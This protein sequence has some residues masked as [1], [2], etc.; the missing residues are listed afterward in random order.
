MAKVPASI[1]ERGAALLGGELVESR[2]IA[3]GDLSD[4]VEIALRDGRRAVVKGGPAPSAEAG[5]LEAIRATGAPAPAVLAHDEATLVIELRPRGGPLEDAWRDLGQALATLHR[6]RGSRY[7]WHCDYAFGH[8]EIENRWSDAWPAF[9][10]ERRLANQAPHLPA[11][12]AHRVESLARTLPER[13]PAAPAHSLLHGDLWAGNVLSANGR[14]SALIDPACYFGHREADL[15]MLTLF[16]SPGPAMLE[17]YGALEAGHE[18]R[19][20][21]YQLWPALVHFRLFGDGYRPLVETL[22]SAARA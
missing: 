16:G 19:R 15:A 9:W 3:G 17:A 10:A 20:P 11:G 7:G 2:A 21:I 14:I 6:A 13:L 18:T 12:L 5:M 1:A 8:V 22:L 4:V